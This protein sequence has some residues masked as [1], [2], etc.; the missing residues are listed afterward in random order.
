MYNLSGLDRELLHLPAGEGD[1]APSVRL[2]PT[3]HP[4]LE[5]LIMYRIFRAGEPSPR[6]SRARPRPCHHPSVLI[7]HPL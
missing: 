5:S 7:S 1:A 4:T 6:P 2:L 3:T